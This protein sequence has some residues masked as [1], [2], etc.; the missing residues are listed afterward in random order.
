LSATGGASWLCD[1]AATS[2]AMSRN[3]EAVRRDSC[4]VDVL[5]APT[6]PFRGGYAAQGG[7]LERQGRADEATSDLREAGEEAKQ[8]LSAADQAKS[9]AES[10]GQKVKDAFNN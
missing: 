8:G 6:T 9:A 1:Q 7:S 3:V 5:M 4:G 10:A 2:S